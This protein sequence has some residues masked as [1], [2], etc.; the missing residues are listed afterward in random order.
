MTITPT[1]AVVICVLVILQA[2]KL[3]NLLGVTADL[4]TDAVKMGNLKGVTLLQIA[5]LIIGG[6]MIVNNL[7]SLYVALRMVIQDTGDYP[8][9][10]SSAITRL[11]LVTA[12]MV[13]G[14]LMVKFYRPLAKALHK[15]E[16]SA[17]E[18]SE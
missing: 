5:I 6:T 9:T 14:A 16:A 4:D 15:E 1:V 12:Q 13:V 8:A 17:A 10:Q 3:A 2:G 11:A 18:D 7:T